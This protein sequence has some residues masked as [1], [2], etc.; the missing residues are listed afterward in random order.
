MCGISLFAQFENN[1]LSSE[2]IINKLNFFLKHRGPDECKKKIFKSKNFEVALG[3]TRLS[4]IDIKNGSQPI[5]D[6][7]EKRFSIVFNGEIYNFLDLK[8][9][10]I[11]LGVKFYTNSDTEVILQGFIFFGSS[12]FNE[13]DGMFA[14]IIYDNFKNEIYIA[15]DKFGKKPLYYYYNDKILIISSEVRAINK[16]NIIESNIDYQSYWDF[17]TYRYIPGNNTS[18]SK[19]KKFE[20]GSYYKITQNFFEKTKFKDIN[21][22]FAQKKSE[23]SIDQIHNTFSTLF[24]E[25]VRKRLIGEA[26]IGVLL[27]GGI[28]STA[29]LYEASKFQNIDSY[30]VNF[31]NSDNNYSEL[32]SASIVAK[33]LNSKFNSIEITDQQFLDDII[34]ISEYSD[35]PLADLSIIP[36]NKIC[37]LASQTK[38]VLLSGEGADEIL[39]GYGLNHVKMRLLILKIINF[40]PKSFALIIKKILSNFT[41]K[42]LNILDD[43][44]IKIKDWP[45]FKNYNITKQISDEEKN[46]YKNK[47]LLFDESERFLSQHYSNS[48]E[49]DPINKILSVICQDWLRENVLMKSDK[50]SMHNSIEIRCPYLDHNLSKFLFSISGDKKVVLKN[51]NFQSKY[52]LKNYLLNKISK[53]YIFKKKL[54]FPVPAYKMDTTSIK[55]FVI[56]MLSKK[57]TF[58]E[59]IF[60]KRKILKKLETLLRSNNLIETKDKHFFWSLVTFEI[61]HEKQKQIII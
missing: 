47:N 21:K 17:L 42:N 53:E 16:L 56:E 3:I 59:N 34:N 36:F 41:N 46:I 39:G 49:L 26:P 57:N 7:A 29:I 38:K 61:W 40:Y 32:L 43:H 58:Y 31:T 18:Y 11:N 23:I 4:I 52:I 10:L 9:K 1:I 44:G 27:S 51:L 25:S 12:F 60:D 33:Q 28:D 50:V 19:I 54:G 45:E 8:K 37:L 20:N 24:S 6:Y 14:I 35:E 2:E 5:T 55:N 30:H 48:K 13:L 15:R 22:E